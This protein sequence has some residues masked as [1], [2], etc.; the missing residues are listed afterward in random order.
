MCQPVGQPHN[1]PDVVG[2]VLCLS[3]NMHV[4]FDLGA[5]GI[6]DDFTILGRGGRLALDPEHEVSLEA[7]RYHREHVYRA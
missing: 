2:N 6:A 7:I 3:P 5:I 4:L 1:G